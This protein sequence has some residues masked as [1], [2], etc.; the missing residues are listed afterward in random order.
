MLGGTTLKNFITDT[1]VIRQSPNENGSTFAHGKW[2]RNITTTLTM[3][4]YLEEDL[5]FACG[6]EWQKG[7]SL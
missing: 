6:G 4:F 3:P 7:Y 2:L 1:L 5:K